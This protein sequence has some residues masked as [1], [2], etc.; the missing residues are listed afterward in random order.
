MSDD[1]TQQPHLAAVFALHR[2][3]GRTEQVGELFDSEG[4][5]E[6]TQ[7]L[8]MAGLPDL[9]EEIQIRLGRA[10]HGINLAH[11]AFIEITQLLA[12]KPPRGES[13]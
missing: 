1:H 8:L 3:Q 6:Q 10:A 13:S 11:T 5:H 4:L 2:Q 7:L 12:P 9:P